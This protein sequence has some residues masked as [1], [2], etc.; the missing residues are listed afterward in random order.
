MARLGHML[1]ASKYFA[2]SFKDTVAAMCGSS[3]L[4]YQIVGPAGI[5][6]TVWSQVAE[7]SEAASWPADSVGSEQ[8]RSQ[9]ASSFSTRF[10]CMLE[11]EGTGEGLPGLQ[12]TVR[13]FGV[14]EAFKTVRFL[15]EQELQ[16]QKKSPTAVQTPGEGTDVCV[17]P[18]FDS[19]PVGTIFH[20]LDLR[21][22]AYYG[23]KNF[24]ACATPCCPC[25]IHLWKHAARQRGRAVTG[26]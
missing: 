3:K 21:A 5:S 19:S 2:G 11:I 4:S 16:A 6:L 23:R 24:H 8:H 1:R 7:K 12:A 9:Y 25:S 20:R 26:A 18:K 22:A 17:F 15:V 13:A 10:S 14:A